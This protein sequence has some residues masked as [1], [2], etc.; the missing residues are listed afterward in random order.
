MALNSPLR[1]KPGR[2]MREILNAYAQNAD[3]IDGTDLLI[4][5]LR[6]IRSHLGM[7]VAFVS[8]FEDGRRVFRQVDSA[9]PNAPIKIGD[10]DRLEDSY[11]GGIVSGT[12][13]ELIPDASNEP[14]VSERAVTASL[15]VGAHVSVPL[16]L[17]DGRVYGT[18][19]CFS[20]HPIPSLNTRD[21]AVVRALAELAATQIERGL[22]HSQA[23]EEKHAR[24]RRVIDH[25]ELSSVYQ[26]IYNLPES[27][28][29]GLEC[30]TRFSALPRQTPDV[31]F[32]EAADVGLD[33]ELETRALG[34][35]LRALDLIPPCCYLSVNVSPRTAIGGELITTLNGWPLDRI[36]LEITEHAVIENYGALLE[37]LR[38]MRQS[39]LRIAIDDAGSGYASLRHILN[40]A[41]DIIKLDIDLIRNIQADPA[42]RALALAFSSYGNE[43]G[44]EVVA[45]GVETEAELATLRRL[46]V[47]RVQGYLL[48]RPRSMSNAGDV[49]RLELSNTLPREGA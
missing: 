18:F 47:S 22:A 46:G 11:C 5:I 35:G 48:G 24:I 44:C 42:R 25:G 15:P 28:L 31:W 45:E 10:S 32:A 1:S 20:H 2:S 19:C 7:D 17:S 13:P 36:V 43:I 6:A 37:A 9:K 33:A 49:P 21:L 23:Q 30:L 41:P 3:G 39:G 8:E 16:R 34:L 12:I 38:P 26:P 27:R 4:R 29:A 14:A 40:I